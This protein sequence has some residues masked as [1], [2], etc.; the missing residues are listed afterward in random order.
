MEKESGLGGNVEIKPLATQ[1][2]RRAILGSDFM[3]HNIAHQGVEHPASPIG[4]DHQHRMLA[5]TFV[6]HHQ[7]DAH[8]IGMKPET[9]KQFALGHREVLAV[10]AEFEEGFRFRP[11]VAQTV[12]AQLSTRLSTKGRTATPTMPDT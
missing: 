12:I 3:G 2:N 6:V 9:L 7:N 10:T 1:G 11:E 5:I 8:A 4:V